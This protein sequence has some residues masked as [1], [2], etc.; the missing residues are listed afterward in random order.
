MKTTGTIFGG[1]MRDSDAGPLGQAAISRRLSSL[2]LVAIK[3]LS[4]LRTSAVNHEAQDTSGRAEARPLS[5]TP[6]LN[7]QQIASLWHETYADRDKSGREGRR[8]SV[9][10]GVA[11]QRQR[12]SA[13]QTTVAGL[14][15]AK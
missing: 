9:K 11:E 1:F 4:V 7:G 2:A 5:L 13:K 10:R 8:A 12:G 14:N 3:H 6:T 15:G